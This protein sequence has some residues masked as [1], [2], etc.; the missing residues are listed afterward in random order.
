MRAR[1]VQRLILEYLV[2]WEQT[3]KHRAFDTHIAD[4]IGVDLQIVR[5]NLELLK[6][7]G[8][9]KLGGYI[10]GGPTLGSIARVRLT[11]LGR[12]LEREPDYE[13]H[14]APPSAADNDIARRAAQTAMSLH[15][16]EKDVL[17]YLAR[18]DPAASIT[19]RTIAEA[20]GLHPS[21]ISTMMQ[22]KMR[23]LGYVHWEPLNNSGLVS[24]TTAGRQAVSEFDG[25]V[26]PPQTPDPITEIKQ[27]RLRILE[28]QQARKGDNTPP[29]IVMEIEDLRRELEG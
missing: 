19:V 9:V 4:K 16:I 21:L 26:V 3:N 7:E 2:R 10:A 13:T 20:L 1:E 22:D 29:E 14:A 8:R 12:T 18:Q 27:R 6:R 5:D 24:L 23:L 28:L 11:A 17:R 25:V 15:D